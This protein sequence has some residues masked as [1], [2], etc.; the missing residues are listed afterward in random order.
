MLGLLLVAPALLTLVALTGLPLA[1][2]F[3]DAG[4]PGRRAYLVVDRSGLGLRLAATRRAAYATPADLVLPVTLPR[5]PRLAPSL[6]GA[7]RT[8][9]QGARLALQWAR[10]LP[11][12]LAPARARLAALRARLSFRRPTPAALPLSAWRERLASVSPLVTPET[13][14]AAYPTVA[15]A[16]ALGTLPGAVT[17]A[18]VVKLGP[19]VPSTVLPVSPKA[20]SRRPGRASTGEGYAPAKRTPRPTRPA[21]PTPATREAT[22]RDATPEYQGPTSGHVS[23]C[24]KH[25]IGLPSAPVRSDGRCPCAKVRKVRSDKGHPR[26]PRK[27]AAPLGFAPTPRP[28]LPSPERPTRPTG[29]PAVAQA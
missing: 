16:L 28:V 13:P 12:R 17:V 19:P 7:A 5:T 14:A 23:W 1:L 27:P 18:P 21:D 10:T 26:G 25:P 20:V 2:G 4:L 22:E 6:Q 8:A 11:G 15:R 29:Y 3:L 24:P 9:L